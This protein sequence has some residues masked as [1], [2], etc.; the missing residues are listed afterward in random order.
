LLTAVLQAQND[1]ALKTMCAQLFEIHILI[2][3]ASLKY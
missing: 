3:Q 2:K 1:P